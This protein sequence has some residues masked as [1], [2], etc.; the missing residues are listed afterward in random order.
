MS[1]LMKVTGG[2]QISVPARVRKRWRTDRVLID[3]EG[4]RLTIRPAPNDPIA[5]V[6]GIFKEEFK[7]GPSVDELKRMS[8][9][10]EA[11]IERRKFGD[12]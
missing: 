11:E 7:D 12:R 3:D 2:G 5:A 10:E 8:Q 4:D 6:R 9:E 1:Y